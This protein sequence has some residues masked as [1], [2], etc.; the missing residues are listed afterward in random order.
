M[1]HAFSLPAYYLITPEPASGSDADLAAF[2]A[3]LSAALE[4]GQSFVQLRVKTLDAGAYAAL[5]AAA[6]ARCHAHSARIVLNGPLDAAQALASGADGVHLGS[7]RMLAIA[8]R[9]LPPDRLLSAACHSADELR[10]AE[11]IGANCVTLSPVLPTLSHPGAPTLGW[12]AFE[13][14]AAQASMPV[15][16]LG[17]MTRESLP[18]ARRHRAHGIAGIRGFW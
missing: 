15:Y 8:T 13:A 7:A 2:L 14:C 18:V 4:A 9:P 3:R 16:A 17:G 1:N 10:H 6:V 12:D 5:A 11:R